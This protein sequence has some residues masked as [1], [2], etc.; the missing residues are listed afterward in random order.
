MKRKFLAVIIA[1]AM[2]IAVLPSAAGAAA[3]DGT[4]VTYTA[5]VQTIGWQGDTADGGTAG[6]TGQGLRL[7]ALKI[8]LNNQKYT[9]GISYQAHVQN[10]GWQDWVNDGEICG[11]TGQGLRLEAIRIQLFGDLADH[12][13][14]HYRVHVQTLGWLGWTRNGDP[15]GTAGM[16]K[17]LEA[18]QIVLTEKGQG[19]HDALEAF[20]ENSI[21]SYTTH[22]QQ[23]GWTDVV[24]GGTESGITGQGLRMEGLCLSLSAQNYS[25]GIAYQAHVQNIGWQDWTG[26]GYLAGTTGQGLRMEAIKILLTGEMA[27][28][29]DVVYRAHVQ[30]IGWQDWVSNGADAGTTGQGLRMEGLCLSLSAQN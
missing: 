2:V 12:Y 19:P 23:I 26:D 25:G 20:Y 29:Y 9:G 11:T 16:G 1:L 8:N 13:E 3:A 18:I 21:I 17:R 6:T 30:N 24:F 4:C 27:A 22:V 15:A 10:I 28:H 14:V 5:H 7:E